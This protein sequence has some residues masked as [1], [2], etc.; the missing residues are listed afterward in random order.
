MDIFN[1]NIGCALG[2]QATKENLTRDQ[3]AQKV[4]D[5]MYGEGALGML[6]LG[7]DRQ[8]RF[9]DFFKLIFQTIKTGSPA[10]TK[11]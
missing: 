11:L 2:W 8:T 6:D 4:Y 5:L 3:I 10:H 1:H 7:D 9:T